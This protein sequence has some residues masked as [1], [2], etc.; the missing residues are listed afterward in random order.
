MK[1]G[2]LVQRLSVPLRIGVV[3]DVDLFETFAKVLYL[4]APTPGW[5]SFDLLEV[6]SEN[7]YAGV[8]T[9]A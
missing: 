9:N 5:V 6:I 8:L 2:D 1:V 7:R 4:G 3:V